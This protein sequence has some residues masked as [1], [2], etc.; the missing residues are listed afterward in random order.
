MFSVQ[1]IFN[2]RPLHRS[3]FTGRAFMNPD[4]NLVSDL[5]RITEAAARITLKGPD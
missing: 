3:L 1:R 5:T 4:P 2:N